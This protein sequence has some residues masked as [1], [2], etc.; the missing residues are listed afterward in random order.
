MH[1]GCT[2]GHGSC[3]SG[4]VGHPRST[5]LTPRAAHHLR[6]DARPT[7]CRMLPCHIGS[8]GRATWKIGSYAID[9]GP[10]DGRALSAHQ[11]EER[12]GRAGD[13]HRHNEPSH[14]QPTHDGH[15][16][17][18]VSSTAISLAKQPITYAL[19]WGGG[20]RTYMVWPWTEGACA[21][22]I[23]THTHTP[24]RNTAQAPMQPAQQGEKK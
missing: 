16:F 10:G 19:G 20:N 1:C 9:M 3:S 18:G 6:C 7:W 23:H 11:K 17:S 2:C 22:R 4:R 5:V 24:Q 12:G 13:I 8:T 15:P 21:T 14:H